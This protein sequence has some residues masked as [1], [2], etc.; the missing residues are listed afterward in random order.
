MAWVEST[1]RAVAV[2]G[3][4][5]LFRATFAGCR[6]LTPLR[7]PVS[8]REKRARGLFLGKSHI[9]QAIGRAASTAPTPGI[10]GA[11]WKTVLRIQRVS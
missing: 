3:W 2:G 4:R 7:R 5:L 10:A 11:L 6:R 1:H 8:R 9:A